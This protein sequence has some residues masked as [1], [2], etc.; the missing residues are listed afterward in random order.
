MRCLTVCCPWSWALIYSTKRVE[1]RGWAT[2]YRGPLLIHCGKSTRFMTEFFPTGE[3]VPS[4]A[5]DPSGMAMGVVDLVGCVRP[6]DLKLNLWAHGPWC[7]VVA[8]PRPVKPFPI[9][10]KT[11]LFEVPDELIEYV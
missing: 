4:E 5:R 11:L 9:R 10:G 3:P 7:W 8:N 1:N 6:D 2:A